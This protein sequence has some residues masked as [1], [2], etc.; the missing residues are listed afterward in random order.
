MRGIVKG[1]LN[2]GGASIT[3]HYSIQVDMTN[4]TTKDVTISAINVSKSIAIFNVQTTNGATAPSNLYQIKIKDATTINIT[5]GTASS[6]GNFIN[7]EV[8]EFNNVKSKQT[9]DYSYTANWSNNITINN[10]NKDKCFVFVSGYTTTYG[11][12][13]EHVQYGYYLSSNTNLVLNAYPSMNI[14]F[15]VQII[16][17]S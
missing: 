9:V 5:R 13:I 14:N 1:G 4:L 6:I 10:V 8:Y 15:H 7:I 17:L 2:D 12:G 11:T 16:E 3:Q